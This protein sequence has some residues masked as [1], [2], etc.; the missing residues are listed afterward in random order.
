MGILMNM[1]NMRTETY[2]QNIFDELVSYDKKIAYV[3]HAKSVRKIATAYCKLLFPHIKSLDEMSVE[4]L[5][6]FKKL[7]TEYCLLP[8]IEARS[9]IY[10]QCKLI[11]SEY[12]HNTMPKFII[13]DEND[14]ETQNIDS[15][16]NNVE[17]RK[18]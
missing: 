14:E 11:D 7:Y 3:R 6:I 10:E 8:A 16:E 15:D 13:S 4:N 2:S 9:Y 1:L 18:N 12:K 5:N 17:I